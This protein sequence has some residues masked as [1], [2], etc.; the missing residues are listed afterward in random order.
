MNQPSIF[1]NTKKGLAVYW[2]RLLPPINLPG[3]QKA[4]EKYKSFYLD[5][6]VTKIA[7]RIL[8]HNQGIKEILYEWTQPLDFKS[9]LLPL[10]RRKSYSGNMNVTSHHWSGL[11]LYP[12][13]LLAG[14]Q[15]PRDRLRSNYRSSWSWTVYI[16][17]QLHDCTQELI[18]N[19]KAASQIEIAQQ[20]VVTP[21]LHSKSLLLRTWPSGFLIRSVIRYLYAC[22][23]SD[24]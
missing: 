5:V 16:N 4:D 23:C 10:L 17:Q 12:H 22:R 3:P 11:I 6:F 2:H 18:R 15:T 13:P 24:I 20:T 7:C 9:K 8:V 14:N 21:P 19:R 1:G